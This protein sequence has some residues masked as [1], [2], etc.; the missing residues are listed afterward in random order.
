MWTL[1]DGRP[2]RVATLNIERGIEFDAI[3]AV[4]DDLDADIMLLQEVDRF[5]TRRF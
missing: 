1:G 5:R 2:L 4:L 3:A